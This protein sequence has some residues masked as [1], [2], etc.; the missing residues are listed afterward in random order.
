MTAQMNKTQKYYIAYMDI[1]GYKEYLKNNPDKAQE[2]LNTIL[3]AVERAKIS[4]SNFESKTM[5]MYQMDGGLRLKIFSDNIL[6]CMPVGNGKDEICRAIVFLIAVAS[7]QRGMVLQHGL[8]TRGGITLGELFIN[9]DIVFGQGI[10]DAVSL[11]AKAEYPCIIVSDELPKKLHSLLSDVTEQYNKIRTLIQ[12]Q[13][14]HVDFSSEEK[15]YLDD[16]LVNVVKEVYY[17]RS[18]QELMLH[19]DKE[20][21]FL[22]YLFDLSFTNL[23]GI[24]FENYVAQIAKNEPKKFK[25]LIGTNEDYAA[26]LLAH[27]DIVINKVVTYCHYRDIDKSNAL[28]IAAREKV[29]RK[30]IWMLRFHIHMCERLN[31]KQGMFAFRFGC[32]PDVLRQIVEIV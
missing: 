29:I 5:P 22:N 14:Q 8:I 21:V 10:I 6:L 27:K 12:K 28:L 7:I 18:L 30:Y 23:L 1:L 13:E 19:F 2:Y 4:V 20:P 32:D 15:K 11:E 16:N 17:Y 9:E 24:A 26:I 31:F 3:D 25:D